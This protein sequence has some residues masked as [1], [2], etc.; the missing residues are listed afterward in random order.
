MKNK[1]QIENLAHQLPRYSYSL[2][3]KQ[4]EPI[5]LIYIGS[6]GDIKNHL[7]KAGWALSD[8]I[9]ILS[10]LKCFW[11]SLANRTYR[12]GPMWP[13]FIKG[14]Q[15]SMGFE[16]PTQSD[17]YRR[18]HHLRIWKTRY[19]LGKEQV[20]VGTISYDRGIGF[21]RHSPIPAHHISPNMKNE[22]EYLAR[23]LDLLKTVYIR[24]SKSEKGVINT[25]DPYIWDGK[26]LVLDLSQ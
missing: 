23:T 2:H 15:N 8:K 13:S 21:I 18:R 24:L 17:T 22:E 3:G 10:T 20:W 1:N 7:G 19:H 26:A 14:K 25:G 4:M 6:K 9:S 11:A 16:M 5:T 12:T